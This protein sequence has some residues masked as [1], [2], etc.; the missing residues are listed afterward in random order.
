[1]ISTLLIANRGEI[2]CRI[3]ATARALGIRTVAVYSDV[4]A[5]ALHVQA[6]D[7]A[8]E[9]GPAPAAESY[10]R[11]DR[12][13]EAARATGA[14]A[15]HPGYGFLSENADFADACAAAGLIFVGPPASAIRA[16][17]SKAEAKA[18][19][20]P[21]G[22]PLVPG[23]HGTDQD[24]A[25]LA[26]EAESIGYPVLLKASAG[27]GGRGMRIVERAEDLAD[28]IDS[29]KRE[30]AAAFA[31]DRLLIEKYLQ[32]PRHVELQIFA[33]S[34]GGAVHL[35]ERDCSVQRRHQKVLEEAPAPDLDNATR[36]AMGEAAVAAARAVGYVGAGTVEFILDASG[37]Y[38]ME[39]NTRLQVEHPVTE[40][41]TGVD[42]VEW[43]LKVADGAP[44][45]LRQDQL[46]V[47][48]HAMEV[49]LYAEDPVDFR[50]QTGRI[51]HLRFPGAPARVD[52]GIRAG[53]TVSVHYDPMI[54]KLIVHGR[55]RS[56]AVARLVAALAETEIAGLVTNQPFLARL[57]AH[58]AF[59]EGDVH[60]GFIE[61]H[62]AELTPPSAT[63]T[64]QI[65]ALA[66]LAARQELAA[67][68]RHRA[69]R[70]GDPMS[71]W[72]DTTGWRLNEPAMHRFTFAQGDAAHEL[73]L[74]S[75]GGGTRLRG[76]GEDIQIRS[77]SADHE[78][79]RAEVAGEPVAARFVAVDNRITLFLSDGPH[80]F[81]WIDLLASSETAGEADG[82]LTA[83]MP[84]KI[85]AVH[86]TAGQSAARGDS[87]V[88]L[89][90]MKMEHTITAPFDGVVEAV[91]FVPGDL[92]E[93]GADLLDFAPA[94][95]G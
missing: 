8:V 92:V 17:G 20:E 5:D 50:P 13:I 6:C 74:L 27:G 78:A 56:D 12:I 29:A 37:F 41:I 71:P 60:T 49:R 10:L 57:A 39:M 25:L 38:F 87:L 94:D 75:D 84:G 88:V 65:L 80:V 34:H 52:T 3:A 59:A 32:R 86:V 77:I 7:L 55:D 85:V 89:E 22:V 43:Q 31:D 67:R 81:D 19:M 23:Y 33:D 24:P 35:F 1:M 28:A 93:E 4:D 63:A 73:V 9:I 64:P 36:T 42:L 40:L 68:A 11:G 21:A 76:A 45:P 48:G 30:S 61:E 70:S 66:A 90:A 79:V 44:L 15:V 47:D 53:D 91:H 69:A 54:A 83:P 82:R 26:K 2:A 72:N 16:M 62:G 18:L 14:D 51:D 95:E 58:P 46:A